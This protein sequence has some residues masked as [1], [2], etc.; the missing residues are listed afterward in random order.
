MEGTLGSPIFTSEPT[1]NA[2][3]SSVS[4]FSFLEGTLIDE[5]VFLSRAL[6]VGIEGVR[7]GFLGCCPGVDEEGFGP[8]R[9]EAIGDFLTS[10]RDR[11][12]SMS[13]R[14]QRL[15]ENDRLVF[16]RLSVLLSASREGA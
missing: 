1:S 11:Y 2:A 8:T 15:S 3:K 4:I 16:D 6:A 5:R 9:E 10:L 12:Q 14:K 13:R 7:G